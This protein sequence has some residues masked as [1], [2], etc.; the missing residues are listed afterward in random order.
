MGEPFD[1]GVDG[2]DRLV[3]EL[4]GGTGEVA[5]AHQLLS[6]A[7]SWDAG[8]RVERQ[9]ARD[10]QGSS[11]VAC[12]AASLRP[13]PPGERATTGRIARSLGSACQAQARRTASG[14]RAH[15][16]QRSGPSPARPWRNTV[17]GVAR[18][19]PALSRCGPPPVTSRPARGE[20]ARSPG[21]AA[22]PGGQRTP[23]STARR[24][25]DV[26][27]GNRGRGRGGCR[28]LGSR[29]TQAVPGR[30]HRQGVRWPR[31]SGLAVPACLVGWS[32]PGNQ[33]RGGEPS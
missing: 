11:N 21:Q 1:L 26:R 30:P 9:V 6:D 16:E 29:R 19:A 7:G 10:R 27:A 8:P 33:A 20:R 12:A 25:P 24:Q 2:S 15:G 18:A 22:R 14:A 4:S 3:R 31:G 28:A 17:G 32:E 13:L 5:H 23:R